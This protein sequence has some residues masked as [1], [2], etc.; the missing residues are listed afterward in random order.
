M[1]FK[2][3]KQTFLVDKH[4]DVSNVKILIVDDDKHIRDLLLEMLS[5]M[6]YKV[7]T[8]SSGDEGLR[9]FL[10]DCFGLV[11]TDFKMPGMD[12][13]NFANHIK[14]SSPNT[15][16]VLITGEEKDSIMEKIDGSCV[17]SALFK[18][19]RFMEVLETVHR[20]LMS[21]D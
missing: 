8:A 6:G 3:T 5:I 9:L 17:D 4:T 12:G 10:N 1:N 16:V 7:V 2:E 13:L 19:F 11:V 21:V 15:P 14:K 20:M 18:P